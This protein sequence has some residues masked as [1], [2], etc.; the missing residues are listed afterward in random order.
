MTDLTRRRL[1][2]GAAALTLPAF[3]QPGFVRPAMAETVDIA[4]AK[5][6]S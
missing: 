3:V 6:A 4:A 2:T 5:R 1:I